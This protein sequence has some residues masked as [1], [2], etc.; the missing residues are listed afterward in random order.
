LSGAVRAELTLDDDRHFEPNSRLTL[1]G[2]FGEK[3]AE[4]EFLRRQHGRSVLKFIGIDSI[5]EA[6]QLIGAELRIR[7]SDLLPVPEG[8]FYTF[9]LKGCKVYAAG[10][11]LGTVTD[12]LDYG[13]TEILK[14]DLDEHETLIPF[15]E[16]YLGKIDL[17]ARRIDVELPEGLR[18]LNK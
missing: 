6:E 2:A 17:E 8:S 15:A 5:D 18:D 12:V 10:E 3:E 13:G 11:Y 16:S 14:V 9:E 4:V 7:T 1:A